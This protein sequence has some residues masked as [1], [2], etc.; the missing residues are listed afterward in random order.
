MQIIASISILELYFSTETPL[1]TV[2]HI[3]K[4]F[5]SYTATINSQEL[6]YLANRLQ[7]YGSEFKNS[8]RQFCI[9]QN[10][11]F[12]PSLPI[13]LA[14]PPATPEHVNSHPFIPLNFFLP[15][16]KLPFPLNI[17]EI[18]A[19]DYRRQ[20]ATHLL[21]IKASL[22]RKHLPI[23]M[24]YVTPCLLRGSPHGGD[25]QNYFLTY[26]Y[27]NSKQFKQKITHCF[28]TFKLNLPRL[29]VYALDWNIICKLTFHDSAQPPI[30][31]LDDSEKLLLQNNLVYITGI[32]LSNALLENNAILRDSFG[33][34]Y[35]SLFF[36]NIFKDHILKNGY[37]ARSLKFSSSSNII[38]LSYHFQTFFQ[39][40]ELGQLLS[41]I[42]L[43]SNNALYPYL[44]MQRT[45]EMHQ[46]NTKELPTSLPPT[47]QPSPPTDIALHYSQ[48]PL[49][50]LPIAFHKATH[51][52]MDSFHPQLID[53]Q[54]YNTE[55][56]C[57]QVA[58]NLNSLIY[59]VEI[60]SPLRKLNMHQF[61]PCIFRK[62]EKFESNTPIYQHY[63]SFI[64]IQS[65]QDAVEK[66]EASQEAMNNSDTNRGV[67]ILYSWLTNTSSAPLD[68]DKY[69]SQS[70]FFIWSCIHLTGALTALSSYF[71]QRLKANNQHPL[72]MYCYD[73][74][75]KVI[76]PLCQNLWHNHAVLTTPP[77]EHTELLDSP[78]LHDN[79]THQISTFI[80]SNLAAQ[81]ASS[82]LEE[83]QQFQTSS[84]TQ[85]TIY[86]NSINQFAS[87]FTQN[88]D[89]AT[90][91]TENTQDSSETH[92]GTSTDMQPKTVEASR[93]GSSPTIPIQLDDSTDMQQE[94]V[95]STRIGSSPTSPIQLDSSPASSTP[96]SP[97]PTN[98]HSVPSSNKETYQQFEDTPEPSS[99]LPH[100]A[101]MPTAP[102]PNGTIDT[103]TH[104]TLKADATYPESFYYPGM[105][106]ARQY[107]NFAQA[108]SSA[109]A[110]PTDSPYIPVNDEV[111]FLPP[112][113]PMMNTNQFDSYFDNLVLR[114]Q[115]ST[116]NRV[117]ADDLADLDTIAMDTIDLNSLISK[118]QEASGDRFTTDDG[119]ANLQ[120]STLKNNDDASLQA[121]I[122]SLITTSIA[123]TLSNNDE[124]S[125]EHANSLPTTL[126]TPTTPT[127]PT[128]PIK[129]TPPSTPTANRR[130]PLSEVTQIASPSALDYFYSDDTSNMPLEPAAMAALMTRLI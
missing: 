79:F 55:A 59:L 10:R 123:P 87:L 47:I 27:L 109:A 72:N 8:E 82:L 30:K 97:A 6:N 73:L 117:N 121:S 103:F 42:T 102:Y 62:I 16:I 60:S 101:S 129:P 41:P 28:E 110:F 108:P 29:F 34:G 75:P 130:S 43:T 76:R 31:Q 3:A 126:S 32:L 14:V 5:N 19:N 49:L 128:S 88:L 63:L 21:A 37:D 45:I 83:E 11:F 80:Y 7:N 40:N 122:E 111:Q 96:A 106:Q 52:N 69:S 39:Q 113:N 2:I 127:T 35:S 112:P 15:N 57:K 85:R 70:A 84:L 18:T 116:A 67:N 124:A 95:E 115:H 71:P 33:I 9:I 20:I 24:Q 17:H 119:F 58:Q 68:E 91:A 105:E 81:N 74:Y 1:P 98:T 78:Y 13:I 90:K 53:I 48:Y 94:V 118:I 56:F 54:N 120:I 77:E 61:I 25:E 99:E 38:D 66:L 86:P 104:S 23:D 89:V 100:T 44:E 92:L 26:I 125:A 64:Y 93:I 107:G 114:A 36:V 4:N 46:L 65:I 12:Y 22:A 51:T 50:P